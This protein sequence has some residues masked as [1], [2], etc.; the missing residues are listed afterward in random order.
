MALTPVVAAAALAAT[1]GC[2]RPSSAAPSTATSPAPTVAALTI[3]APGVPAEVATGFVVGDGL[4]L[5]VAHA[6]VPGARVSVRVAGQPSTT[7]RVVLTDPTLDA[8]VLAVRGAVGV[9]STAEPRPGPVRILLGRADDDRQPAR[10]E[11]LRRIQVSVRAAGTAHGT[12]P[13]RAGFELRFAAR[14]GDS[15]SPVINE[16]GGVVGMVFGTASSVRPVTYATAMSAL[17]PLIEKAPRI[18]QADPG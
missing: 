8:A 4:L 13:R 15:G 12:T 7:G 2:G 17:T 14:P 16:N 11:L 10:V 1:G 18:A 5:T 6:L 9:P 3:T